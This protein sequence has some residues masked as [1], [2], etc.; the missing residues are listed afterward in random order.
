MQPASRQRLAFALLF[1][2]P[3]MWSANYIVARS[4]IGVVE[5]HMLALLRWTLALALM[6]VFAGRTLVSNYA[7]WRA[8]WPRMIVLGAL[9][10]WVC[11]AFVY[12]GAATTVAV[13]IS[14][15]YAI[16]PVMIAAASAMFFADRLGAVQGAGVALAF[17][18]TLFVLARGSWDNLAAV[19]FT[20]GDGWILVAVVSWTVYSLLLRKWP[21]ALDPFSRLAAICAGGIIVLVPFTVVEAAILGLPDFASPR[22]WLLVLVVALLPG[23][24]AYQ[25][26]SFM[27]RELGPARTGLVLY[28]GPLWAALVAWWLLDEPPRWH[29]FAGA[30]LILPGIFLATRG[31]ARR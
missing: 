3:G 7:E 22:L 17:A 15:L 6:L 28:L 29:H 20:I 16:A 8:E 21:S 4:A 25:A 10:M 30:A 9:G 26:Y 23:F 12:I 24:G 18:G 14:L 31:P 19:R 2:T 13:N 11:G 1:I 5:P 27:Q